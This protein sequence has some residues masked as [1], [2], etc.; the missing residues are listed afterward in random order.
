MRCVGRHLRITEQIDPDRNAEV[1]ALT[2]ALLAHAPAGVT[3]VVP[4][5]GSV[6]VE[7]DADQLDRDEVDRWI[8]V[9]SGAP[10]DPVDARQVDIPVRYGGVDLAELASDAG[11]EPHEVAEIHAATDY[12]VYAVGFQPGFPFLGEVDARIRKGR[13]AHPRTRVP[14]HSVGIAGA[15]TGV[16]PL[17]SPGGWNLIGTA[18][19]ALYDPHREPPFLLEPGDRVRFLPSDGLDPP[20]PTTLELL[21]GAP[22]RPTLA[23]RSAGLLDLIVDGGRIAVGRY[24]L[25]RSGALDAPAATLANRLVANPHDAPLLELNLAGPELEALAPAIVAVT[26]AGVRPQ[27]NGITMD[28]WTSFRI[29]PGDVLRFVPSDDG[30]RGY[31]ALA[32]GIA[33]D[34]FLGSASVDV[35]ARIGRP[36]AAGDVLGRAGPSRAR[37]GFAFRPYLGVVRRGVPTPIRIGHGP[38]SDAEALDALTRSSY[39]IH[40]ADRVGMHLDGPDVAITELLSEATPLGAVQV[41]SGGRPLILL[42]DRGTIGGYAVPAVVVPDDLPRLAQ[43]R[44]GD[45]IRFVLDRQART[46]A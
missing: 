26:G 20:E 3:D 43:L 13:R 35:R 24:G 44:Q 34:R 46:T 15:Q 36:L 19:E 42:N 21:P 45:R 31:L 9:S 6:Y 27:R 4:S 2:Q 1:Q 12:L 38:Q 5:Y 10:P 33:S 7:V 22:D 18:L 32:G 40:S 17:S 11:L 8:Q 16:Y 30:A 14:A 23:V 29:E 41:T 25:A 37:A 28:R 39:R